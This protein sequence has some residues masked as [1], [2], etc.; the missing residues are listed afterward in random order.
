LLLTLFRGFAVSTGPV[1]RAFL[2]AIF[3][4]G[5]LGQPLVLFALRSAAAERII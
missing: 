2:D 5:V 4:A 3:S 1:V